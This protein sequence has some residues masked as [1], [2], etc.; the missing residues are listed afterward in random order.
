VAADVP[1][2]V[3][4]ILASEEAF[5]QSLCA[6]RGASVCNVRSDCLKETGYAQHPTTFLAS[7]AAIV[8]GAGI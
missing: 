2:P 7:I 5:D 6:D 4:A 8:F 1:D 3:I